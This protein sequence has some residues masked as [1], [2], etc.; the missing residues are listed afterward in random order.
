MSD[1][2]AAPQTVKDK[3]TPAPPGPAAPVFRRLLRMLR[4][5]YGT[6]ALALVLLLLSTPAE[7]FPGLTWMY[8]TDRLVL[9]TG[10]RSGAILGWIFSFNGH[11][12]GK[13]H[14]LFSAVACMFA[15]YVFAE[16]FGTLST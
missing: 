2:P 15:V 13:I 4:P 10:T 3:P 6:I 7:L 14:L 5:H 8:V 9:G 12:T 16:T 11:I 1:V